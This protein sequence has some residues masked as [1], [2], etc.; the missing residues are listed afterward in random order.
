MY[1]RSII[2]VCLTFFGSQICHVTAQNIVNPKLENITKEV[3]LSFKNED[4]ERFINIHTDLQTIK[5]YSWRYIDSTNLKFL[6]EKSYR[7][8]LYESSII[9]YFEHQRANN[10]LQTFYYLSEI[11]KA[12]VKE[13]DLDS[14]LFFKYCSYAIWS[15]YLLESITDTKIIMAC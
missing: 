6:K 1:L 5:D 10:W 7:T 14:A 4:Y 11:N 3:W 15:F 8:D 12:P 9:R 13:L 2:C